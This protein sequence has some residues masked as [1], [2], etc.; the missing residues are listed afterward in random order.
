MCHMLSPWHVTNNPRFS[1]IRFSWILM[2][3]HGFS[4]DV[5]D[6]H[7]FSQILTWRHKLDSYIF[8]NAHS[9][10]HT[11]TILCHT[12]PHE[13][14]HPDPFAQCCA[15]W[16]LTLRPLC[17]TL[18]HMNVSSINRSLAQW[19]PMVGK[20]LAITS[21]RSVTKLDCRLPGNSW[22]GYT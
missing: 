1:W 19:Y 14:S 2:D 22:E 3:P 17:A 8:M 6:S 5:M 7:K 11:P 20:A 16:I 4:Y 15:T 9:N 21:C 10:T 13:R 12:V 18:C